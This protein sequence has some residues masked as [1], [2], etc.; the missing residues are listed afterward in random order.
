MK[1]N[2]QTR[3]QLDKAAGSTWAD[4]AQARA[5][6][7]WDWPGWLSRGYLTILASQPGAGKSA[8]CLHLAAAYIDGRP[9]PDG[10]PFTTGRGKILWCESEDGHQMNLDRLLTWGLDPAHIVTP[11]G[12]P[13][14]NFKLANKQDVFDLVAPA[15]RADVRLI[16]L[17]S[18]S[19]LTSGNTSPRLLRDVVAALADLARRSRKP[20][21]LTHHL[22]K[23]TTLDGDGPLNLDRLL[24]SS[25]IAQVPRVV[26]SLDLPD[27]ADPGNRRLSVIKNNLGPIPDPVGMRIDDNGLH[28]GPPPQPPTGQSEHDRAIT[29]L[30]QLLT[31]S[32]LPANQIIE[33]AHAAGLSERTLR[34]AKNYLRIKSNK[35]P[36][37]W[38]WQ[39]P[40]D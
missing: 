40:P 11:L 37:Q 22:R 35:D 6:T 18:L 16:V 5:P 3:R 15:A 7:H 27:P 38:T 30:Q 13:E 17:D 34:R 9:W 10:A 36:N 23:R 24:G 29:F 19:G 4:L 25:F 20:I 1:P 21:L 28:F 33:Q 12:D 31:D 2:H 39:L 14:R 26:W 32:P 8:L